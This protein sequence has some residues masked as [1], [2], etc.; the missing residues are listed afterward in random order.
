MMDV[1]PSRVFLPLAGSG[2]LSSITFILIKHAFIPY[3]SLNTG[4][5]SVVVLVS[6]LGMLLPLLRRTIVVSL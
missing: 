2:I 6:G 1:I 5:E 4:R 3:F